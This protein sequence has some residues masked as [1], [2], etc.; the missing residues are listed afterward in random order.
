MTVWLQFYH[1]SYWIQTE[2]FSTLVLS[3]VSAL[4]CGHAPWLWH[5]LSHESNQWKRSAVV[6]AC[7]AGL[8]ILA[9]SWNIFVLLNF[10]AYHGCRPSFV[11]GGRMVG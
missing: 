3:I 8:W 10:V 7:L 6:L 2:W 11:R 1:V 5:H 9:L 4:F